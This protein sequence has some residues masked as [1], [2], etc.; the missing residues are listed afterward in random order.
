MLVDYVRGQ[1]KLQMPG[2]RVGQPGGMG[3]NVRLGMCLEV[4]RHSRK[5]WEKRC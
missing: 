1:A 2:K 3:Y 5:S 4:E